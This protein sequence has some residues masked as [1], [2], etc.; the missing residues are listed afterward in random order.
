V[1][2]MA[3]GLG[4]PATCRAAFAALPRVA[5]IGTHLLH[6]PAFV[7]GFRGWGRGLRR[8]VGAW[9]SQKPANGEPDDA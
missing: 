7:E 2:A 9:Y 1:L 4:D 8:A 6:F 5:R 3:A